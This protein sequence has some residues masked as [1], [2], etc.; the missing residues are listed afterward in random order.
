MVYV[1]RHG[2]PARVTLRGRRH[3]V[4]QVRDRWRIDDEW[5]RDRPIARMY[6][7]VVLEDGATLTLFQ[8]MAT[9]RW[10]VQTGV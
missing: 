6:H 4:A 8:D 7:E 2:Q 9:Q 5:W 10:Y 1:D 3:A